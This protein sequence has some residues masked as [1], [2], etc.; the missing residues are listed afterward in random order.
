M[1]GRRGDYGSIRT[2]TKQDADTLVRLFEQTIDAEKTGV[3]KYIDRYT[4]ENRIRVIIEEGFVVGAYIYN[5]SRYSNPYTK[6]LH[7]GRVVWLEQLMVF[8]G[9]QQRGYGKGLMSDLLQIQTKEFRLI[10]LQ[11]LVA[12]YQQFDFEVVE[13]GIRKGNEYFVMRKHI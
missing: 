12:Y 13:T 10:C 11:P 7:K 5:I 9:V 8:P 4:R 3:P 1:I 6:V 2:A